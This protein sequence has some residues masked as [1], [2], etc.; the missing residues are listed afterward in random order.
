M[1]IV[2]E[3]APH[4]FANLDDV[5]THQELTDVAAE[6]KRLAGFDREAL[7]ARPA[8]AWL[9]RGEGTG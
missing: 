4:G 6:Y 5:I 1:Q 2:E 7:N 8:P 9:R 3:R